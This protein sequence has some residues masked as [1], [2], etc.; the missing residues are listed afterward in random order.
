RSAPPVPTCLC[1]R[2][3]AQ[4]RVPRDGPRRAAP[5][6]ARVGRR[7][8]AH[9]GGDLALRGGDDR[10]DGR[11]QRSAARARHPARRAGGRRP[12]TA[13]R[14]PRARLRRL[15]V[16][17]VPAGTDRRRALGD[18]VTRGRA[19]P[20]APPVREQLGERWAVDV[21]AVMHTWGAPRVRLVGVEAAVV[22]GTVHGGGTGGPGSTE[23]TAPG[24][25]YGVPRPQLDRAPIV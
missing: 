4:R 5:K 3:G 6:A 19:G 21:V 22:A 15:P 2:R 10:L 14:S 8:G 7:G 11:G 25:C 12:G 18:A 20:T 16:P 24:G 13:R 9:R 1:Q 17:H 23:R